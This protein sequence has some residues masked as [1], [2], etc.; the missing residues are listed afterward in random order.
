MIERTLRESIHDGEKE[1]LQLPVASRE[2]REAAWR[3]AGVKPPWE[4]RT[5]GTL[6][7]DIQGRKRRL[8]LLTK[9]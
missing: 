9:A 6:D 5:G 2:R 8:T 3:K 4:R 1:H 7:A